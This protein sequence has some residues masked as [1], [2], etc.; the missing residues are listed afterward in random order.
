M[1]REHICKLNHF[2]CEQIA[3]QDGSLKAVILVISIK[4]KCTKAK[5]D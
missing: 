2:L 4:Q 1:S 3:T 5:K